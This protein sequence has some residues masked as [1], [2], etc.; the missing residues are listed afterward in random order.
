[1]KENKNNMN[2]K[3]FGWM[4][5]M[6]ITTIIGVV[7]FCK[8]LHCN[9]LQN[10][11]V[12]QNVDGTVEVRRAGGWFVRMFP[13]IWEYPK[14][15]VEICTEADKDA[16]KMQFANKTTASLECQVG[17]R[18]DST[19]DEQVIRLHQLVEGKD[20]KIWRIV[21]TSIQTAVQRIAS[22]YTP[23]ESV[24]KFDEFETKMTKSI[25]HDPELLNKGIDIVSFTCAGLPIY[26]PETVTQFNKQKD[27]D[28]KRRL[29]EAAK[30][31]F[32]AETITTAAQYAREIA[33]FKGKADAETMKLTTEADRIKKLAEIDA[34][35][36]VEVEKLAK[37]EK[38]VQMNKQKEVALIEAEQHL[39]VAVIQMKTEAANLAAIKIQA[40]QKIESAKA[41]KQEIELSGAVTEQQRLMLEV[42]MKTKIGVAE[43]YAKGISGAKLPQMWV[44]S[45][46]GGTNGG[47]AIN[48]LEMLIN[49]MT[50]EKLN[51]VA[52]HAA[53]K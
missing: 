9:D 49:T 38:I 46:A 13:R 30:I 36:K 4:I 43:A 14:A 18:I 7:I 47:P 5:T 34:Q 26:D 23:S 27:A 29:A 51:A 33:E 2:S 12:V 22:Q 32:E 42:E 50:L 52:P 39:G 17:Y 28:L 8:M 35:K 41:K 37:E 45:G 53:T 10:L 1:M 6:T 48:P 16:F 44:T 15:C 3:A 25:L 24:E 11:M 40:E 31:T 21:Q 20:E 19:N